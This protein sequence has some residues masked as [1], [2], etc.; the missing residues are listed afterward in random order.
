MVVSV[1]IDLIELAKRAYE[2]SKTVANVELKE[3]IVSLRDE[4]VNIKHENVSLKDELLETK[5]K[6]MELRT[7][8]ELESSLVFHD[9]CY[10]KRTDN[11]KE[12]GPYCSSC[13]D[14]KKKLV[15]LL[16]LDFNPEYS[17]CPNCKSQIHLLRGRKA[18]P[19]QFV[20]D[21]DSY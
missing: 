18:E 11:E 9:D 14:D 2:L 6:N 20:G 10:W 7:K 3:A 5:K 15:R 16:F 13:F 4:C 19:M 1:K 8:L 12:D 17:M 21:G